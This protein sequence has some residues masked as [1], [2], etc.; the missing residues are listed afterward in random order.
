MVL[1]DTSQTDDI[2]Q[3]CSSYKMPK[4]YRI[5]WFYDHTCSHCLKDAQEM[6]IV[7]DSLEN[8]GQLN[9][10]V[11]AVCHTTDIENWKKYIKRY[12][13]TW[14]N[15]GGNK[16]NVDWREAYHIKSNPQ[17]F[18]INRDHV[19]I[20]NKNIQKNLIPQ[21]LKDYERIEAEKQRLKNK[22]R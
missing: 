11:Y 20:L 2:S 7:Y 18:I 3:W 10:D 15:L 22:Q 5:L 9:F 17:F 4:Q 16:G 1:P 21:F 12:N 6:K 13:F 19:I 14:L 8:I